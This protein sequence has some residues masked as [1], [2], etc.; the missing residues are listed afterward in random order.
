MP[1]IVGI[2]GRI[3][4]ARAARELR[5]MVDALRHEDFYVTGT[6]VD[7]GL[8]AYVGWIARKDS[9]SDG[10]PLQNKRRGIGLVL[11]GEEF[12]SPEAIQGLNERGHGPS[13]LVQLYEEDPKFPA[14][15]NGRF[16]GLLID[17]N[18]GTAMLFNDRYGMH[19]IYYHESR[20]AFY[21]AAEAKAILA[22]RPECRRLDPR[23]FGE[24]VTLSAVL[25]N[26]TLFE[27]VQVL[28]P[29]SQWTFRNGSLERKGSY[30]HPG[31]W[32]DQEKLDPEAYYEE[33][34][35]VFTRN[36]PRYFNG[37]EPV[38]MSLTGGLDTRMILAS[39]RFQPGS[40]PSYTF[41]SM[42]NEN[43][44]VRVARQVAKICDQPHQVITPGKEFLSQFP[45]YAERAVYLTDGCVDVGRAPDL[46]LNEK[47]RKIAPVRMT[48]NYGGEILRCVRAFKPEE[49][50][51][52]LF[53]PDLLPWT[54]LASKTYHSIAGGHPVSFAVFKQAPWHHYGILSL[55][56]TQLS[57][58]SPYL[59]ND[60]VRTVFRS[61]E[62]AL[63][64]NDVC[65][66]LIADGNQALLRIPTDRGLAGRGGRLLRGSYRSL[67]QLQ[68][69]AEYAYDMGM[70]QWLCS[71][72]HRLAGLHLENLF[73]GRHKVFHFRLWYRDALAGY[74]QEILLDSQ[75]LA[76]PYVERKRMEQIVRGHLKGDRNYT[77][78]IHKVLTLELI[79]RLFLDSNRHACPDRMNATFDSSPASDSLEASA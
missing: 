71:I 17:R 66:R 8:G 30:F 14:G 16:H 4:P 63:K 38:A 72:D 46:Y 27:S 44:D 9:F 57:M 59:D 19:R 37:P 51:R 22:V 7:D 24:F 61:P 49:P 21:F 68:F 56:Q 52:G 43:R 26:R 79:H 64:N 60:F 11:S 40:L 15:L 76:R 2:I 54:S 69:K 12:P 35:G 70:P 29:A 36:L 74:L 62:S 20:D 50:S 34:R 58:R 55:E 77:N 75:S 25:E 33:L 47:A 31:E 23:G 3:P 1:G 42:F 53:H 41:G 13:Y 32:E 39:Q 28:P 45:H 73:L 65:L 5:Q 18:C 67:L 48:G 10:M 78:A 6:C